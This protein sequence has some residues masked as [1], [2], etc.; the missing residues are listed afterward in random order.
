MIG[1]GDDF[2]ALAC[3]DYLVKL[4]PTLSIRYQANLL[5][6]DLDIFIEG[7]IKIFLSKYIGLPCI[8]GRA[9]IYIEGSKFSAL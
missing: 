9:L 6:I 4:I 8:L 2:I 1:E 5:V 3:E 7:C